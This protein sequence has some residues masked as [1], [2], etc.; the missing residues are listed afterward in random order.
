V[1]AL[2]LDFMLDEVAR[3]HQGRGDFARQ[4]SEAKTGQAIA[5]ISQGAGAEPKTAL[6]MEAPR[7]MRR[8]LMPLSCRAISAPALATTTLPSSR[9]SSDWSSAMP[10]AV[11][12]P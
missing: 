4:D 7:T 9:H 10:W 8:L 12:R 2:F 3:R 5:A 1:R 6:A 11:H